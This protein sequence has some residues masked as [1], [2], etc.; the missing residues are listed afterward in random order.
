[1]IQYLDKKNRLLFVSSGIGGYAFGTFY[2]KNVGMGKHRVKSSDLPVRVTREEAEADFE[3]YLI[4]HG[5]VPVTIDDV[6]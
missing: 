5:L 1:M 4:K 2:R 6:E 3:K